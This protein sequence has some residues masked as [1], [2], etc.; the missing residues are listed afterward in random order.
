MR[1]RAITLLICLELA[2]VL[3]LLAAMYRQM[4]TTCH[5]QQ[6]EAGSSTKV[7][8][9][10]LAELRALQGPL[11]EVG[12]WMGALNRAMAADREQGPTG[13]PGAGTTVA[14]V[15]SITRAHR[16]APTTPSPRGEP[17]DDA[18]GKD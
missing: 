1:D 14:P 2:G 10:L 16:G 12:R 9:E 6:R 3:G 8:E 7:G 4:R 11:T 15:V 17:P 18:R 13:P 5:R